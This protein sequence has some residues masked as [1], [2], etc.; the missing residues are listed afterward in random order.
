VNG[1]LLAKGPENVIDTKLETPL[2]LSCPVNSNGVSG[3][4][5]DQVPHY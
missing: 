3:I 4:F 2:K 1:H 5:V